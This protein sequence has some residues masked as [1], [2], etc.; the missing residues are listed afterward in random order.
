[1]SVTIQLDLPDALV[2]EAKASGLLES[3]PIGEL[4]TMEL[5]RRKSAAELSKVKPRS[6]KRWT[7]LRCDPG[8]GKL[9][10]RA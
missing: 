5:R 2:K 8:V 4:L 1:M 7:N 9:L 6:H 10:S 3:A